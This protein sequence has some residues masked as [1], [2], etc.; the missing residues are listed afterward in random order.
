[1]IDN[2]KKTIFGIITSSNNY[3]QAYNLNKEIYDEIY[4]KFGNF[5]ILDLSNYKLFERN[6]SFSKK[7]I[8]SYVK[9]FKPK[10]LN[11]FFTFFKNKTF[12]AFNNIGKTF[13]FFRIYYLLSRI[14]LKQILLMNIGYPE[15]EVELQEN[16]QKI[17]LNNFIYYLSRKI[18]YILFRLLTVISIFP[19]ID[20]YFECSRSIINHMNNVP[21]K[22]IEKI[23]PFL[24]LA[25]FKKIYSIN[26]RAYSN[27]Y[28]LSNRY[29]CFIDGYFA[30]QDRII[31]EGKVD[32]YQKKKYYDYLNNL[33]IYLNKVF[34]KKIIICIHPKNDDKYFKKKFKKFKILR[35]KTNQIIKDSYIVLFHE[36]SSV[37]DA[38][39]YGKKIISL[40]STLL[41]KYL[42]NR[43][44]SY[45][46]LFGIK[47]L[48]LEKKYS[49]K[50]NA[51]L[52]EL[53]SDNKKI[54]K[55]IKSNLVTDKNK[56]GKHKVI[57][58][59]KKEFLNQ[60]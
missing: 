50:K 45:T 20:V 6:R 44:E 2:G 8:P 5:Y 21:S 46:R 35:F 22:K 51:L 10:N 47:S 1:M 41:G 28:K 55:Y 43:I 53:N 37:L 27:Q 12:I 25:Y 23:I 7:K 19:K 30:H 26:C 31:R 42:Q 52:K 38:I 48:D 32:L 36:S 13:S 24:R 14:N 15:N 59:I 11:E 56:L 4:K 54:K 16:N 29:I 60:K 58:V 49:F 39:I 33:F 18:S 3:D 9:V 34:K 40:N 17:Y 57:E